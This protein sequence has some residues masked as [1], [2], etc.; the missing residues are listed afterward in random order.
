MT[1]IRIGNDIPFTWTITRD[2]APEDFTGRSP[3]LSLRDPAGRRCPLNYTIEGNVLSATFY[4]I[5]QRRTGVYTLTLTENKGREGQAILDHVACWELVP[6]SYLE[7]G[8][9]CP[10]LSILRPVLSGSF[11]IS[12]P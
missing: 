1:R 3:E 7:G 9:S 12:T 4:G 6:A 5:H 11:D 2:G 10:S 8:E